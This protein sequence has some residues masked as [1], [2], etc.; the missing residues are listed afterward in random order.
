M[1]ILQKIFTGYC[2]LLSLCQNPQAAAVTLLCRQECQRSAV[3]CLFTNFEKTE[4]T[5]PDDRVLS[6]SRAGAVY[7]S[8][9]LLDPSS[10]SHKGTGAIPVIAEHTHIADA[11]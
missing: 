6:I 3:F 11:T 8:R 5:Y 9:L 1:S 2:K 10:D 4:V 7:L